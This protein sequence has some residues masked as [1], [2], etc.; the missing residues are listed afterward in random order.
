MAVKSAINARKAML[1]LLSL[2]SAIAL[3]ARSEVQEEA[4]LLESCGSGCVSISLVNTSERAIC[5]QNDVMPYDGVLGANVFKL[6]SETD[7]SIAEFLLIEPSFVIEANLADLVRLLRPRAAAKSDVHVGSYY[8]LQPNLRYR[9][10]Y[11]ARAYFC[12]EFGN[13]ELGYIRLLG[14]TTLGVEID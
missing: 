4:V 12:D 2:M 3:S 13:D 14:H 9:V 1:T 5:V 8:A 10:T 7:G 11:T 6:E